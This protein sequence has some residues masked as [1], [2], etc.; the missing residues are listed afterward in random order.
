MARKMF[1]L[2][3]LS[4]VIVCGIT[5]AFSVWT[6]SLLDKYEKV[7]SRALEVGVPKLK[8]LNNDVFAE[9]Y[10]PAGVE[11]IG[12]GNIDL[13]SPLGTPMGVV[14]FT[15]DYKTINATPEDIVKH[16]KSLLVAKGWHE[17]QELTDQT[18]EDFHT[19]HRNSA[20]IHL[21]LFYSQYTQ[22]YYIGITHDFWKQEFSPPPPTGIVGKIR[23]SLNPYS[24]PP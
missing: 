2:V 15:A 11:L 14:Q 12:T 20:T 18:L 3:I 24:C 16:Y 9:L 17:D 10:P 1:F 4:I 13:W 5:A 23:C 8:E 22:E 21:D 19:F 7:Y 6:K